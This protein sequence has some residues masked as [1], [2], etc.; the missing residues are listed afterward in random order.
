[1]RGSRDTAGLTLM[2]VI[3]AMALLAVALLAL[4]AA[5][6]AA[7]LAVHQGR[8]LT[9]AATL[10]QEVIEGAKMSG[11]AAVTE[12]GL[13]D[14]YAAAPAGYAGY[15]RSIQVE[16]LVADGAVVM[17]R[18]TVTTRFSVQG[19]QVPVSLVTLLAP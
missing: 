1:M 5:Y 2:E 17:K 11:F 15:T 10:A 12:A 9:T 14:A 8:Q 4:A 18:L 7:Y 6:P 19:T 13:Q 3:I 16:D